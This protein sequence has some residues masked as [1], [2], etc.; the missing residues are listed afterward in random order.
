[1]TGVRDP[2]RAKLLR[3]LHAR[4]RELG[5]DEDLRRS[6]QLAVTGKESARDMTVAKLGRVLDS[7][8]RKRTPRGDSL[9]RHAMAKKLRAL[10]MSGW[11]LGVVR[12]RTD[13][14]LCAYVAQALGL[15]AARWAKDRMSAAVEEVK[16]L[17]AREGGV[18][19]SPVRIVWDGGRV[20]TRDAPRVRVLE[21]QWR[22]LQELGEVRIAGALDHYVARIVGVGVRALDTLEDEQLDEAIRV[23]GMR[24]RKAQK[25]AAG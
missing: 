17:L 24:I 16:R 10:W 13:E 15:D 19:W 3:T 8:S 2:R 12:D 4:A 1:M 21:A 7:F 22:R 9:P 5:M 6:I 11:H 20:E 14:A 23:L 18:D 25:R